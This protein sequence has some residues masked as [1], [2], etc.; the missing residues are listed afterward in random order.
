LEAVV[1]FCSIASGSSGNCIYVGT[2]EANILID[3][4]ISAKRIC[5]GLKG[6]DIDPVELDGIFIT[7]EHVD[8]VQGLQVFAKKYNTDIYGTRKTLKAICSKY[9]GN[10]GQGRMIEINPDIDIY[11]KDAIIHPFAVQHDAADPVGYRVESGG[12]NFAV[13]TDLGCFDDYIINN[14]KELD[15]ICIEANHDINMLMVGKYPYS[16]KQRVS[17]PKGHLSNDACAKLLCRIY[18]PRLKSILLIHLSKDNNY[19]ELAYETVRAELL[20]S[21][22][23]SCVALD[24]AGRNTPS[25]I[26]SIL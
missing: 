19:A 3:A 7:H 5:E 18:S 2:A 23:N 21:C 8:H 1:E 26:F 10:F 25:D 13:A 22:C 15:G 4:G 16:L 12:K 6:I 14:L 20:T 11:L 9:D 17:G 24:V